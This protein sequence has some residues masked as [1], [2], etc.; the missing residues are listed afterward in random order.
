MND[1]MAKNESKKYN[2]FES[3]EKSKR[4][5]SVFIEKAICFIKDPKTNEVI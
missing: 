4:A 1:A 5:I 3:E 2:P